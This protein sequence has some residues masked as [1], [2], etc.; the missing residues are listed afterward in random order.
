[1]NQPNIL[2][3]SDDAAF[4]KE[5]T[6]RWR[7]E[8]NQPAFTLL[9]SDRQ[10]RF[11]KDAFD[12]AVVGGV[13]GPHL[14]EV[15][16][17]LSGMDKPVLAIVDDPLTCATIRPQFPQCIA[18]HRVEG[19]GDVLVAVGSQVLMRMNAEARMRRAES[20]RETLDREAALGRYVLDM[21]H[22]L[23]NALTSILGNAEL[24]LLEQ[25][26]LSA[27]MLGQLDTIRSMSLRIH[28]AL[29]RFS[30]LEKE[31]NFSEG[32]KLAP[33]RPQAAAC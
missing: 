25:A 4:S 30:S 24:L 22:P 33:A 2:V 5:V 3:I 7:S 1:L 17:L 18:F 16:M 27:P 32:Q 28:E 26:N 6:S 21:R 10:L 14:I 8:A 31:M 29:Q 20:D 12:M 15:L 23:N 13:I 19:W 9:G 11:T